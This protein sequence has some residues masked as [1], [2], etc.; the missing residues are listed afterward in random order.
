LGSPTGNATIGTQNTATLNIV[1]NDSSLQFSGPTFIVNEDGTAI[2]AVTVTRTGSTAGAVSATVNPSNGTATAPGDYNNAPIV[3]NFASGDSAPKTVIIP[4][5][6]DS[7]PEPNETVNLSLGSPTGN[8]TIGTQ[9]TATLNIVDDD[10]VLQFSSD[11]FSVRED[12]TLLQAVTL[13]RTGS[14]SRA[15]SATVTLSGG[16][17]TPAVDYEATPIVVSFAI[18]DFA[19]KVLSFQI[20]NDNEVEV[21]GETVNLSLGSPTGNALIGGPN[22]AIFTIEDD[23]PLSSQTSQNANLSAASIVGDSITD[24]PLAS[25]IDSNKVSNVGQDGIPLQGGNTDIENND[26]TNANISDALTWGGIPLQDS[27]LFAGSALPTVD[28]L[29]NFITNFLNPVG[30]TSGIGTPN[31]LINYNDLLGGTGPNPIAGVGASLDAFNLFPTS[32]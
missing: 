21:G 7:L 24:F 25:A 9:N 14:T 28:M 20:A 2:A 23:D 27:S 15:V 18:G 3:V 6:N 29:S 12:G 4:I 1:D 32:V 17:A 26:I 31:V 30:T 5:G 19:P 13:T 16:T 22:P 10:S 11:K 8:A